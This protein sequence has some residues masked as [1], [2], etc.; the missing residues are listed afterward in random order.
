M[1]TQKK[2]IIF[3]I[4]AVKMTISFGQ[5]KKI[6]TQSMAQSPAYIALNKPS[7]NQNSRNQQYAEVNT[8]TSASGMQL[9]DPG[10]TGNSCQDISIRYEIPGYVML[11]RILLAGNIHEQIGG[12][13]DQ[14]LEWQNMPNATTQTK[15]QMNDLLQKQ[16]DNLQSIQ[17]NL[18]NDCKPVDFQSYSA[19]INA[20]VRFNDPVSGSMGLMRANDN[21]DVNVMDLFNGVPFA[22]LDAAPVK[23]TILIYKK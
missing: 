2:I 10:C 12:L 3:L 4:C 21:G 16:I 15:Q 1:N 8:H 6:P 13:L 5:I 9:A 20:D 19:R 22:A 11:D 23:A 7:A 18:E 17:D 14:Q